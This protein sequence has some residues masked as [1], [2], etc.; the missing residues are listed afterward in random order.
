MH[1]RAWLLL[2][3]IAAT[4]AASS[5][6]AQ[7]VAPTG[8]KHH[9]EAIHSSPDRCKY[10]RKYC[11]PNAAGM[12]DYISWYYCDMAE[13][14]ALG[15]GILAAWTAMLFSTIGIASSDFFCPNLATIANNLGMSQSVA[16]VTFLAFGNGSPDVFS[17]FAAFKAHSGSL[18][19]GELLGA[20]A[21]ITSVVAG[22]MA[23]ISPFKVSRRSFLR[24]A[25]FFLVAVMMTMVLLADGRLRLWESV[26]MIV[27]YVL[28]VAY[29]L[30]GTWIHG[31]Q[32]KAKV[33]DSRI[34]GQ[35]APAG[36]EPRPDI[37]SDDDEAALLENDI[38]AL[39][40]G[41]ES[42]EDN[43]LVE[44]YIDINTS[45][46]ITGKP[47]NSAKNSVRPSLLGALEFRS[48]M[49][50]DDGI[51]PT[52]PSKRRRTRAGSTVLQPRQRTFSSNT[53]SGNQSLSP[54]II[55][56]AWAKGGGEGRI[57]LPG[58]TP[59]R[60]SSRS[61]QE[62]PFEEIA[63]S[64]LRKQNPIELLPSA[65][66]SPAAPPPALKISAPD[67]HDLEE[68]PFAEAWKHSSEATS[69]APLSPA[70]T[71]EAMGETH[72]GPLHVDVPCAETMTD[73]AHDHRAPG[74]A[75][76]PRYWPSSVL[77]PPIE[78][79]GLLFPTLT[80]FQT[81]SWTSRILS[82]L[83]LPS[84]FVLSI[85][86]P[87]VNPPVNQ[88]DAERSEEAAADT[89]VSVSKDDAHRITAHRGWN[90]WLTCVQCL[91]GPLLL[92]TTLY[93]GESMWIPLLV[94]AIVGLA[95]LSL[96]LTFTRADKRPRYHS[97]LCFVGF[98][99][100]VTWISTIANEV[101]GTLQAFGT[102]LG[103][104]DAILGLTVFAVGNS[105][106]DFVADVTVARMGF[107]Q[108]AISGVFGGPMLNILIGI[109]ISGIY[110]NLTKHHVY[111]ASISPTLIVSGASLLVT[112][113]VLLVAVPHNNYM[114]TRG[115]GV[116]LC[117]IFLVGMITS[118]LVEMYI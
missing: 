91:L 42:D 7:V 50:S 100:S 34:R 79:R 17:T 35:Y 115:L 1:V 5:E 14:P 45:M 108:M 107:S 59:S 23:I 89:P 97:W 105:L 38:N 95:C 93:V 22:A 30:L 28:Y 92:S 2:S 51:S 52:L 55:D 4:A 8:M 86:L 114:M 13:T 111:N 19:I 106:G 18:A 41:N 96:T 68:N 43:A 6:N 26:L 104:S 49:S 58:R 110:I 20:A 63:S 31:T 117:C 69:I 24:D 78:L 113:L 3:A 33:N 112:L 80:G 99:I 61:D 21:F 16:G 46:S 36:E 102:I 65:V 66:Q 25:G 98:I 9:C 44:S 83:A 82:I 32:T 101:V 88:R 81:Q 15:F 85:T 74:Q 60:C 56:D 70:Q 77:P 94:A 118:V 67:G 103:I 53:I 47:Y 37:D 116:A 40:R 12:V 39:E 57:S 109:G 75:W 84:V 54:S 29:V 72:R 27:F 48:L 10:A 71:Y 76:V 90:H 73:Y 11:S 62:T 64:S 87:V